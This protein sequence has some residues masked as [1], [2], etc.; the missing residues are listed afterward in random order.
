MDA[1]HIKMSVR[2]PFSNAD[3]QKGIWFLGTEGPDIRTQIS[4]ARY[5]CNFQCK[6]FPQ[7]VTKPLKL[8]LRSKSAPIMKQTESIGAFFY[9]LWL[10]FRPTQGGL[11]KSLFRSWMSET[12]DHLFPSSHHPFHSRFSLHP[13]FFSI[14]TLSSADRE[15]KNQFRE[16][17]GNC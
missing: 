11:R 8:D 7:A 14:Q 17:C 12:V 5:R 10:A 16:K 6:H 1:S 2:V 3:T 15:K 13:L 9:F 4:R